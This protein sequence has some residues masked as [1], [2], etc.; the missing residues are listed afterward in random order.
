MEHLSL[1]MGKRTV[2]FLWRNATLSIYKLFPGGLEILA[3]NFSNYRGGFGSSCDDCEQDD[4]LT[5]GCDCWTG[6]YDDDEN[7]VYSYSSINLGKAVF[8]S[9]SLLL[10][11]SLTK[12][13]LV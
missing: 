12:A 6:K 3:A 11:C 9:L 4:S 8:F 2:P 13:W 1:R 7:P 5:I 10:L